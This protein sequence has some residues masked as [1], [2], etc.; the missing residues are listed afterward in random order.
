MNGFD[1]Q[2][3]YTRQC[4]V[5]ITSI[6]D[7]SAVHVH[8]R[9]FELNTDML[10]ISYSYS[11]ECLMML[12]ELI[13]YGSV[14]YYGSNDN[15]CTG[16]SLSEILFSFI[17]EKCYFCGLNSTNTDVGVL[18]YICI[19]ILNS[20]FYKRLCGTAST[21]TTK[22]NKYKHALLWHSQHWCH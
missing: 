20:T 22:P 19:Q 21:D 6:G 17:L 8:E 4:R 1:N 5:L 14:L 7:I 15:N 10:L 12:I 11:S 9:Q 16:G 13:N 2:L 18:K 3:L